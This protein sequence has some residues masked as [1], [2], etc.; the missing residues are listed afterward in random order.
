MGHRWRRGAMEHQKYK[1]PHPSDC[2]GEILIPVWKGPSAARAAMA[3]T[4]RTRWAQAALG[5]APGKDELS[6]ALWLQG[7]AEP[8]WWG[9]RS[10]WGWAQHLCPAEPSGWCPAAHCAVQMSGI[11]LEVLSPRPQ[12][13]RSPGNKGS[14]NAAGLSRGGCVLSLGQ[15]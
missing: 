11:R 8:L 1:Y 7:C 3:V 4:G 15:T 6:G 5:H 9:A 14:H 10:R 2:F 12:F 13:P